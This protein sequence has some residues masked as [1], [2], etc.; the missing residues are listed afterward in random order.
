M[1]A[2]L[3]A[4]GFVTLLIKVPASKAWFCP[5]CVGLQ[6]LSDRVYVEAAATAEQKAQL[7]VLVDKAKRRVA[8]F[9][10]SF[11]HVP[12]LFVCFTAVCDAR[13]GGDGAKARAYGPLDFVHVSP[14]G[15]N[16]TVLSH[17]LSHIEFYARVGLFGKTATPSWFDEGLAVIVSDDARYLKPGPV[18]ASKCLS[19]PPSELPARPDGWNQQAAKNRDLYAQAACKV[20]RWMDANGGRSGLV[21]MLP[22]VAAGQRTLP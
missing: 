20:L 5:S 19:E 2:V 22:A 18:T 10:G 3:A 11:D 1:I 13:L 4:A 21:A 9:Y 7:P 8:A 17:E 15:I 6:K 12:T 16:E 14:D